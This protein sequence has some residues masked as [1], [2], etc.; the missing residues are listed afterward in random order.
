MKVD[1][2]SGLLRGRHDGARDSCAQGMDNCF[3]TLQNE[4]QAAS[5]MKKSTHVKDQKQLIHLHKLGGG[6]I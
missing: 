3:L 4:D 6:D 2:I 1:R 5:R